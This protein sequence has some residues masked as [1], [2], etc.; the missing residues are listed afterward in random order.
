MHDEFVNITNIGWPLSKASDTATLQMSKKKK[1]N[2]CHH[3][4]IGTF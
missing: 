1:K 4:D 3:S 2:D